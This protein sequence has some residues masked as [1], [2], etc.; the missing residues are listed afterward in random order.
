[1]YAGDKHYKEEETVTLGDAVIPIIEYHWNNAGGPYENASFLWDE[2]I[3]NGPVFPGMDQEGEDPG[4]ISGASP[5]VGAAA[6]S[7]ISLVN[8]EDTWLKMGRAVGPDSPGLGA[9]TIYFGR[10]FY[11]TKEIPPGGEIFIE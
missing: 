11:A 9:T 1:M 8:V 5:G 2:Y 6:N 4:L 3:W 10:E 7:Y